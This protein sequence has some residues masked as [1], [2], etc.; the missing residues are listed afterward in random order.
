MS[1]IGWAAFLLA[2]G[3]GAVA[4][5]VISVEL[6]QRAGPTRPWGTFAANVTGCLVAGV[7]AGFALHHGLDGHVAIVVAVGFAGSLSTFSTF[8]YETIRLAETGQWT[9]ATTNLVG[10]VV[11]GGAAG[12][13][14][15]VIPSLW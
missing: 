15:L 11:A 2:A 9:T 6:R 4:R 3:C 12:A 8:A 13:L 14:G 5:Y 10:S 1:A 7:V